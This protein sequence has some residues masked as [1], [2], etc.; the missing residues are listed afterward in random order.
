MVHITGS[1]LTIP[2]ILGV[3]A[4]ALC[5][6]MPGNFGLWQRVG[7]ALVLF[8]ISA[9]MGLAGWL[10]TSKRNVFLCRKCGFVIDRSTE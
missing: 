8:C 6:F 2:S 10:L 3:L 4:S 9:V 1:I 7:A 5:L